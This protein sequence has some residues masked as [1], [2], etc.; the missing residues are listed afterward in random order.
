MRDDFDMLAHIPPDLAPA[1]G[2]VHE[3]LVAAG[4][5]LGPVVGQDIGGNDARIVF[6]EAQ[7]C[8]IVK[9]RKPLTNPPSMP[10][11]KP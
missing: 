1:M 2:L 5:V 4:L 7:V 8:L 6:Q 9:C 10:S 11:T 3:P